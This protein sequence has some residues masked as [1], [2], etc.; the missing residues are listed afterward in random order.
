M[1]ING[2]NVNVTTKYAGMEQLPMY[3][4]CPHYDCPARNI[5]GYC[6]STGCTNTKYNGSGTYVIRSVERKE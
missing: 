1:Y 2:I 3:G 6:N 4:K 5:R